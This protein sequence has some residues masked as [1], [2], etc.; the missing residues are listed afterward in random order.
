M[1]YIDAIRYFVV[2]SLFF[3]R[4]TIWLGLGRVVDCLANG[5][6]VVRGRSLL[7]I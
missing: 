5:L 2:V 1:D 7:Y 4:Y 6:E 3:Y